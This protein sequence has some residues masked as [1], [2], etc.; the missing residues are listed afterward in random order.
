MLSSGCDTCSYQRVSYNSCRNRHCPKCQSLARAR[1]LT[2]RL[3]D[4][5]PV[6]YFHVVFTLPEQLAALALQNQRVI[7]NILFTAAK[8]HMTAEHTGATDFDGPHYPALLWRQRLMRISQKFQWTLG[9]SD[10]L[11]GNV[12]VTLGSADLMVT[13]QRLN[14]PDIGACFQQMRGKG[15]SQGRAQPRFRLAH[16]RR[17]VLPAVPLAGDLAFSCRLP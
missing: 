16:D 15:V 9:R 8:V 2:A 4:L 17:S 10:R 1:S 3:A 12:S 13:E 5:L 14:H 11:R 7:Y 6:P